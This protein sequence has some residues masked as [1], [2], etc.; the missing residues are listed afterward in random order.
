LPTLNNI[1]GRS[2]EHLA[3]TILSLVLLCFP[4][5]IWLDVKNI[6]HVNLVQQAHDIDLMITNIRR[7]YSTDVVARVLANHEQSTQILHNYKDVPGAIPLPATLSLELGRII[8]TQQSEISYRFISDYPFRLREKHRL[9]EFERGALA[10]LRT[11]SNKLIINVSS[12]WHLSEVR[13]ISPVIMQA[14]CVECHNRHPDSIKKDW[15]VG[16]VRGLQE[17][18]I[19]QPI[20]TGLWSFKFS[21]VYFLFVASLGMLVIFIQRSQRNTISNINAKLKLAN[22]DALQANDALNAA[23]SGLAQSV[24]TMR[25]LGSI[26]RN[27]TTNLDADT[28]FQLLFRYIDSLLGTSRLTIYRMNADA[29]ALELAFGE[30]DEHIALGTEIDLDCPSSHNAKVARDRQELLIELPLNEDQKSEI[31]GE[32]R[33]LTALFVPLIVADRVLGVM[34]IQ[35]GKERAFC[36]SQRLIFRTLS[37]YGA[38]ALANAEVLSSL[39]KANEQL[40]QQEKLASLGSMAARIAHEINTPLGTA[41]LALSGVENSFVNLQAAMKEGRLSRALF[42]SN[43][44]EG[45]EYTTLALRT[46]S[47]AAE[48]ITI[49]K[50]IAV[51]AGIAN[52]VNLDLSQYL[53]EIVSTVRQELQQNGCEVVVDVSAGL[54][55]RVAP[56]ILTDALSKVLSNVVN[57]AFADGRVGSLQLNAKTNTDGDVIIEVSDDGHGIAPENLPKVFDPFFTTKSTMEGYVGLGLYVAYNNVAHGLNG[58]ISIASTLDQGTTVTIRLKSESDI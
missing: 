27:I 10:S 56:A 20:G 16:D 19:K 37:A 46:A 13:S 18:M 7:F 11:D 32:T 47:R 51:P 14:N 5:A 2:R 22:V 8:A 36:E 30:A 23:N 9:D 50:S 58:F 52:K 57:H 34:A 15:K 12:S 31:P 29:T 25:Q 45:I 49:F 21:L 54:S 4:L 40:L 41:L 1:H 39:H 24:K 38:I 6:T 43:T 3:I 42:E 53:F 35:S 28:V 17:V 55:V 33:M 26:G 48:L 44:L